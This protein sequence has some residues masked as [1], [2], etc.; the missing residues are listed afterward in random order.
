MDLSK[1]IKPFCKIEDCKV[2]SCETKEDAVV[3]V[4]DITKYDKKGNITYRVP[5]TIKYGKILVT[6]IDFSN[7]TVVE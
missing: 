7:A 5:V 6:S 3:A 4:L 2:F 1:K